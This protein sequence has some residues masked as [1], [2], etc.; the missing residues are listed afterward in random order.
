L[1]K[2]GAKV[3]GSKRLLISDPDGNRIFIE[4]EKGQ[5]KPKNVLIE[6]WIGKMT[7]FVD[8]KP[9]TLDV[10]PQI[11]NG[12]TV[13]PLRF[14]AESIQ[15][16]VNYDPKDEKIVINLGFITI[17]LQINST[18]TIIEELIDGKKTSKKI[19]LESPPFTFQGRTLVP[20]RFIT[21]VFGLVVQWDSAEQK[22]TITTG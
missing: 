9:I 10:S 8:G 15:A 18:E 7:A 5:E 6:L 17:T 16:T 4:E 3:D 13:V 21:E 12:R 11:K 14:I 20:V 19:I 2:K 22:I 1:I